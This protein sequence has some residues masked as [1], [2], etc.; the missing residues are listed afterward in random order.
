M[1]SAT[2]NPSQPKSTITV[3]GSLSWPGWLVLWAHA[4]QPSKRNLDRFSRYCTVHPCAYHTDSQIMLHA[5]SVVIG[6]I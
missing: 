2:P 5:T 3:E 6:H 4:S 1:A